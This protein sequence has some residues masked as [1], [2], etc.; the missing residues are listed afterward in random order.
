MVTQEQFR[1]AADRVGID[2]AAAAALYGE[3]YATPLPAESAQLAE[4]AARFAEQNTLSR[5]V[6]TLLYIGI[7]LVIGSHAWWSAVGYHDHGFGA[8]LALTLAYQAG[9]GV[10]VWQACRRGLSTLA[11]ALAAVIVFYTPVSVYAAERLLGFGLHRSYDD[12][13][14][15][16]SQ[17]W[18]VMELIAIAVG[19]LAFWRLRTPFLLLPVLLFGYFLAMD[20]SAHIVGTDSVR[21]LGVAVAIYGALCLAA[22]VALDYRGWRRFALW[23]HLFAMVSAAWALGT[24]VDSPQLALVLAGAGCVAIGVW[25]A[26]SSYL[27]GGGLAVWIGLTALRPAPSTLIVSGLALVGVSIWLS[28]ASSPL[29][30]WLS[31]RTLPAPERR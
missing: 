23:P 7:L 25:L 15:W 8:L 24:L 1:H 10:A 29:R 22:G 19:A 26:R 5:L 2:E 9:F 6:Q 28:L 20:G 4:P 17:G 27:A 11:G 18:A 31:T 16:I 12:F 21:D 13:Y 14:P 3:L 30:S